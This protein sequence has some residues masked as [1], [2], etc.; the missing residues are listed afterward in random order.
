M[1][2]KLYIAGFLLLQVMFGGFI[3]RHLYIH[4]RLVKA[5]GFLLLVAFWYIVF[6]FF[7]QYVER[8]R[9]GLGG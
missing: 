3:L 7:E 9:T 8:Q 4:G 2:L 6:K 1:Q 5:A